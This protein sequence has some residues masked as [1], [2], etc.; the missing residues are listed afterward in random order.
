MNADII[1]NILIITTTKH[2]K[3]KNMSVL[4]LQ[5]AKDYFGEHNIRKIFEIQIYEKMYPVYSMKDTNI[6]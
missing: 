6:I 3:N 4:T 1:T 5:Q 2:T